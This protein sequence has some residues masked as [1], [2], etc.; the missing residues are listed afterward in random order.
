MAKDKVTLSKIAEQLGVSKITVSRALKG[1]PG[2]SESLRREARL[3]A[4]KLGYTY[5]R[6]RSVEGKSRF[7]FLV[8][9]RFFLAGDIFYHEIYYHLNSLCVE[10]NADLFVNILEAGAEA[11][12]SL[13]D[14]IAGADGIFIGGEV[15]EPVVRAIAALSVPCVA[16]DFNVINGLLSCVIIDNYM[17]GIMAAEYLIKQGYRKIGF[18]SADSTSSASDR[19]HGFTRVLGQ[20]NLPFRKEWNIVNYDE[21]ATAYIMDF[22]LPEEM[23]EA[24]ICYN[25]VTAYYFV[26]KLKSSGYH[27]GRDVGIVSIDNTNMA[28]SCAP[29]LTCINIDRSRFAAEAMGLMK[30]QLKG[31][32]A[33]RRVYLNINIVE[34]ESA[35]VKKEARH[36]KVRRL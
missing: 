28:A 3:L 24:F 19:L 12:G 32:A 5:E 16:I 13:P 27:V 33:V 36:E 26:E 2:V 23:P 22:A 31:N 18:V 4:S 30:E 20:K 29:P 11:Q 6:L 15:A 35:P 17:V 7:V 14:D 1:Q 21:A 34:R 25:D 10:N 8:P 9:K